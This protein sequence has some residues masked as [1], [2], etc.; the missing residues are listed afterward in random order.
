MIVKI[1][2]INKDAII[3][4]YV[5]KGDAGLDLYSLEDYVLKPGERKVFF[6]GIKMEFS[7]RYYARIAPKSG[8]ALKYG[9]DTLGGVIDSSY[10]GEYGVILIN[11]GK[12][13]FKIEK[14]MKLAQIIFER[15]G[16]AKFKIVSNL[17]DTERRDGAF[18]HTGD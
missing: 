17:K 13:D 15:I 3:P 4:N 5:I 14:G 12:E 7:K 10:R 8:L 1:L 11:H 6:T 9:I 2:K 16:K 18:G